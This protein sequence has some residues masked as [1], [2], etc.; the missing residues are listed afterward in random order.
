MRR[1]FGLIRGP[2]VNVDPGRNPRRIVPPSVCL[3]GGRSAAECGVGDFSGVGQHELVGAATQGRPRAAGGFLLGSGHDVGPGAQPGWWAG[4][5]AIIVGFGLQAG[6]LATGPL[7]LVQPVLVVKLAFT[8]LLAAAVFHTRVHRREWAAVV[9]MTGGL[10]L[11]LYSLQPSG[12]NHGGAPTL[13]WVAGIVVVLLIVGVL[14]RA[15]ADASHD[16][17]AAYL[18][19]ATGAGFRLRPTT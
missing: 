8:L 5:A 19:V 11:L 18:G 15:G 2:R 6:A 10:A 13:R 17:R 9:G 12:G 3:S 7:A 4:I 16:R 14:F 1:H